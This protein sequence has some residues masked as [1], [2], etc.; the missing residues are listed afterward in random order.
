MFGSLFRKAQA[1]VDNAIGQLVRTVLIALPFVVAMGFA[2]AAAT[3]WLVREYG[4][5][6]GLL[7]LAGR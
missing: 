3:S 1:T 2:T 7:T 6:N 4:L 5:E